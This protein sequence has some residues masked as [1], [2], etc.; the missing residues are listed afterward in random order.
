MGAGVSSR[1]QR[2]GA[3]ALMGA[4]VTLWLAALITGS[5]PLTLLLLAGAF[6]GAALVW[7]RAPAATLTPAEAPPV[8]QRVRVLDSSAIIDGRIPAIVDSRFM[9]GELWIPDFVIQEL[10]R[11][12]DSDDAARRQRG[13]RALEATQALLRSR[14]V[15]TTVHSSAGSGPVDD[16]LVALCRS[17]GA[18]LVTTD[19]NL[20]QVAEATGIHVLNPN[21]LALALKPPHQPG[22]RMQLRVDRPGREAGQGLATLTDGTLVVVE[23]GASHVGRH[24]D[25]V[26]TRERQTEKGRMLFARPATA[27][28]DDAASTT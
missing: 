2:T 25:V 19:H 21:R 1:S 20:H 28:L 23:Q 6:F 12:A 18:D 9:E 13:R 4:S 16:R 8:A 10:Q 3:G 7:L 27:A 26:V 5:L 14:R 11:V 17:H 15:R 22:E 24:L